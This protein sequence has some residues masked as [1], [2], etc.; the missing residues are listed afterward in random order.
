MVSVAVIKKLK[1]SGFAIPDKAVYQGLCDTFWPGR[2][3]VLASKPYFIADGAHNRDAAK[4]LAETI[5]FYFT[6]KRIIYIIGM[7]RDKEQDEILKETCPLAE[8]V[9]TISTKGERGFSA[10]DLACI[11]GKYHSNVTAADSVEEAVELAYL[12]ADEKAV[13]IAFGSLSYLGNLI[14]TV[15]KASA[16]KGGK[17]I[18]RSLHGKQRKN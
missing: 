17:N 10:Y 2:F 11:A 6:N 3:Q 13:I 12:L 5:R 4:R 8:Q 7:L 16:I 1:E 18:G 15:E 14:K 9:L